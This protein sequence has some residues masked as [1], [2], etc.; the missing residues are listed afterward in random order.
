MKRWLLKTGASTVDG[1]ELADAP[2]P[3]PGPGEVRVRVR[4]V[5]LNYRDQIL[6][7]GQFGQTAT[8]EVVPVSDGAG[9]IHAVGEGVDEWSIGDR[10]TSVYYRSWIDGPPAPDQGFGLGSGAENG[11]LA[12]YVVLKADRVM[13]APPSLSFEEAATLP[14]AALTAWSALNGDRPYARRV[15]PGDK[16]LVLGTGGVSLFALLLARAGGA[17]VIAT[18]SQDGKLDRVRAMGAIDTV[19]YRDTPNWGEEVY[20]RTGGVDFLV[21]AIGG[22]A[23]DQSIAALAPGGQVAF[24]GLFNQ[25]QAAPNFMFLMMKGGSIRGTSVGSRA[26]YKDLLGFIEEH[27]VKPPIGPVFGLDKAKDAY[28]AAVSP[29]AF[30]KVVIQMPG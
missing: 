8:Q 5:S 27:G 30:G 26:A 22:E 24:M 11:M 20:V 21:N 18:S 3:E 14:C 25:A 1:L 15:G 10:V 4:A 23:M 7:T 19:D 13:A 12:E 28:R 9:E 16:V 6:V 29:D 2:I 17:E